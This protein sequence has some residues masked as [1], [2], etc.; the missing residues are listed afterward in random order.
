MFESATRLC[1]FAWHLCLGVSADFRQVERGIV[2]AHGF[3]EEVLFSIQR[4][5]QRNGVNP[6]FSREGL[7]I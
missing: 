1:D 4:A 3:T 7:G 2:E 5:F 6:T